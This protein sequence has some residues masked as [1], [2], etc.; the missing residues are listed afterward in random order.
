VRKEPANKIKAPA[1]QLEWGRKGESWAR[2]SCGP[3]PTALEILVQKG[4]VYNRTK[5]NSKVSIKSRHC[6]KITYKCF[7]CG[8]IRTTLPHRITETTRIFPEVQDPMRTDR[9]HLGLFD[10]RARSGTIP[11]GGKGFFL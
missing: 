5:C 10:S 3:R 2:G 9:K 1:S 6:S 11:G 4:N 7:P 8:L